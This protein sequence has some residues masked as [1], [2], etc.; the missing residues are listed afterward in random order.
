[1]RDDLARR[2][3]LDQ[4]AAKAQ[5]RHRLDTGVLAVASTSVRGSASWPDPSRPAEAFADAAAL[6]SD[7]LLDRFAFAG[8]AADVA[9]QAEAPFDAGASRVDFGP[10]H[11][12]D[13]RRGLR[14]LARE[15][16]P[17]LLR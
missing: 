4:Q 5:E 10:P 3:R 8:A 15:V 17:R 13:R 14:L 16:A 7:D 9:A 2:R 11:G 12:I 1:M 6:V